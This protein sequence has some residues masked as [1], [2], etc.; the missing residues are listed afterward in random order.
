[1]RINILS[2]KKAE[3]KKDALIVFVHGFTGGSDTWIRKDNLKSI[4]DHLRDD[5]ELS[6]SYDFA[7]AEYF[8]KI[9]DLLEKPSWILAKLSGRKKKLHKNIDIN[10]ISQML[11]SE[12]RY[13]CKEYKTIVLVAHSMGGLVSKSYIL[14]EI[15]AFERGKINTALPIQ[16]FISLAVPHRGATL[17]SFGKMVA[18]NPQIRDLD[19]LSSIVTEMN[20]KWVEF[21]RFVPETLYFQG[22]QDQIVPDTATV[23]NEGR[24]P[25]VIYTN[26]DHFSIVTTGIDDIVVEVIKDRCKSLLQQN[27]SS[28]STKQSQTVANKT[29]LKD[30]AK[31]GSDTKEKPSETTYDFVFDF[32][33]RFKANG[34]T[35]ADVIN[36]L[37]SKNLDKDFLIQWSPELWEAKKACES[38]YEEVKNHLK[39]SSIFFNQK[40]ETI[41]SLVSYIP[42]A[43][44]GAESIMEG[45]AE[46]IPKLIKGM[47]FERQ[48][49]LGCKVSLI[50]F[51]SHCNIKALETLCYPLT[52]NLLENTDYHYKSIVAQFPDEIFSTV[53]FYHYVYNLDKEAMES[54]S[55]YS[56]KDPE[57][58]ALANVKYGLTVVGNKASLDNK[59]H[60]YKFYDQVF[61]PQIE[62]QMIGKPETVKYDLDRK[63]Y[64][65]EHRSPCY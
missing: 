56:L 34:I 17:A 63:I 9:T 58:V 11:Q 55:L 33:S 1:M 19:P 38:V 5:E 18:G 44:R 10:G 45:A 51:L 35:V 62:F 27:S 28:T 15:D 40:E 49:T 60:N 7:V 52:F 14:G 36:K 22:K 24:N 12:I 32:N 21:S 37:D 2:D 59:D 13:R 50:N 42:S 4:L 64:M 16:L 30:P 65:K 43:L 8:T 57:G 39:E 29:Q 6:K 46:R 31:P 41:E 25:E 26:D 3:E 23:G 20:D 61:V 48:G 47:S 54:V 53:G